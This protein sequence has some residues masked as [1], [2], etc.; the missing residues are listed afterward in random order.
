[1]IGLTDKILLKINKKKQKEDLPTLLYQNISTM[2][3]FKITPEKWSNLSRIDRKVLYYYRVMESYYIE[4]VNEKHSKDLK[5]EQM[6]QEFLNK[7]PAQNV[8]RG[9]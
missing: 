5:K 2:K 4:Q 8:R 9:R 3:E 1:M 7:L 6:K